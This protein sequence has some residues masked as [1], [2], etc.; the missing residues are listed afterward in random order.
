MRPLI[1]ILLALAIVVLAVALA[2]RFGQAKPLATVKYVD[3]DRFMGD[4]YVIANIPTFIETDA[5]NAIES[6]RLDEDGTIDTVFTF[7]DGGFDGELKRYN[8]RGFVLNT[9]TNAEWGMQFVWPIKADYRV[10]YL[11]TDYRTTIIGRNRRDYVWIMAREPSID[12]AEF[13]AM[14]RHIAGSGYDTGKLQR[15][16]Q[17]W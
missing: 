2:S 5:H 15:V 16:P 10:I 6:Y 11:D 8:P 13:D 3:L 14:V 1:V 4:W 9:E 7:L 12:P 17:Q